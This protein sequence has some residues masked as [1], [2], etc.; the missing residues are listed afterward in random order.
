MN[1]AETI[2]ALDPGIG[3]TGYAILKGSQQKIDTITYGCIETKTGLPTSDRVK[4]IFDRLSVLI[5]HY[6]PVSMVLEQVFFTKNQKTAIVVGQAQGV[7]LLVAAQ[8]NMPVTFVTPLQIKQTLTGY[9]AAEKQQVE[10]MVMVLLGL[11]EKIK[12]DDTADALAC[13]ITYLS[14]HK[15]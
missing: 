15:F 4:I 5:A 10:K 14:T 9:G 3:R 13:G 12:I 1:V 6:K 8:N 7:M 11:T 2:L